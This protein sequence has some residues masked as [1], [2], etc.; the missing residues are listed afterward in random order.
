MGKLTFTVE[1]LTPGFISGADQDEVEVRSASLRGLLRWW[2]RAG[3]E[4]DTPALADAES[5][6]F[7]SSDAGA[8]SPLAV[9]VRWGDRKIVPAGHPAPKSG[10]E[11]EYTRGGQLNTTDV[12]P[13]LAYGPV[14]LLTRAEK[15]DATRGGDTKFLDGRGQPLRGPVFIRPALAPGSRFDLVL[16]WRDGRMSGARI[17]EIVDATA[18]WATLGGLGTRSRKGFGAVRASLASADGVGVPDGL[19]QRFERTSSQLLETAWDD[20]AP[21]PPWPRYSLRVVHR[22]SPHATWQEALGHAGLAYKCGRPKGEQRWIGGDAE[23]RRASS[24]LLTVVRQCDRFVGVAALIP[25]LKD[26]VRGDA[27]MRE[28]VGS[29]SGWHLG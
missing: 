3:Q 4:G 12:L 2:W 26:G 16:R 22:T 25:C 5:Q 27:E 6:L 29:F 21:L 8:K 17:A 23:P 24:I 7:G 18:A 28:F 11:Y 9:A 19:Q 14:R 20:R 15:D 13:Y 1:V 10:V